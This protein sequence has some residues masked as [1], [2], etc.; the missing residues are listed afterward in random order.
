MLISY[1]QI[2]TNHLVARWN[3]VNIYLYHD[4]TFFITL[5]E[6]GESSQQAR[7]ESWLGQMWREP[8][9]PL[10]DGYSTNPFIRIFWPTLK[11]PWI[12]KDD[13]FKISL[14]P[15]YIMFLKLMFT[16]FV[17]IYRSFQ[18]CAKSKSD[19]IYK[20]KVSYY[21]YMVLTYFKF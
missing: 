13:E 21:I 11:V 10:P 4:L 5:E 8:C 7:V 6:E 19:Y 9:G 2:S 18:I 17:Q 1:Y 20:K 15:N 12:A 3:N 16:L 14:L